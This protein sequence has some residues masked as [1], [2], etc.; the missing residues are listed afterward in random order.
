MAQTPEYTVRLRTP[1]EHQRE[2]ETPESLT[3]AK[4]SGKSML[5][6]WRSPAVGHRCCTTK[7]HSTAGL[8]S[9]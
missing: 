4:A 9:R 2:K 8:P 5:P 6:M 1:H 3:S 7:S